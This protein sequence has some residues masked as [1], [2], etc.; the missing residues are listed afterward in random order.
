MNYKLL[1]QFE[2]VLSAHLPCLNSWQQANVALFSYGVIQAESCQQGAIARAVSSAE[3]VESTARRF[4]RWLKNDAVDLPAFFAAWSRWVVRSVGGEHLT[5]LVDE[6]KLH[7]RIGVMMVGLAWQGR[8]L[9]LAWHT[10]RANSEADYPAEGQVGMIG[11]LLEHVKAGVG[12]DVSVLVL[13]DRG[14][15]CS[16]ALCRVVEALGWHYLFRVTCQTKIVTEDADYTI[17]RQVQP[18]EVWMQSGQVF[19]KRGRIPAHARAVWGMGYT[20]P[21]ALVTNDERLTGH[22]YARRNWQEQSFRDLKSGGWHWGDSHLRSPQHVANLLILLAIAYTWMI[23]LGSQ[24]VAAGF[25]QP[26]V[27]RPNGT[28]RRLWSLFREGLRYFAQV[29]Q[30]HTVCL[31][32]TFI[33]DTRL[34]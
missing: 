2:Q 19:K 12:T 26:L 28:L 17:A 11:A 4:R 13:A 21:W 3:Q 15:G 1:Y 14:I 27:R 31:G 23:A 20:E 10:Y 9:P 34:T 30:R 29:V 18:G 25:A 7:D 8:C 5:L 24:A 22:E 6:T 32:L 16:P 33:P